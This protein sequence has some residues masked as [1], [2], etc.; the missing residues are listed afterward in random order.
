MRGSALRPDRG[1]HLLARAVIAALCARAGLGVCVFSCSYALHGVLSTGLHAYCAA[2]P[3]TP[4]IE[5]ERRARRMVVPTD[6]EQ[7]KQRLRELGHPVTL[8]GE[9]VRVVS[10]CCWLGVCG[11]V[12]W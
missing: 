8:F 7:V 10:W 2:V 6:A 3:W 12:V 4:Q 5:A 11:C 1:A 9:D